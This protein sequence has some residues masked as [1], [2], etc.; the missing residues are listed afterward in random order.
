MTRKHPQV[1]LSSRTA[2]CVCERKARL[3]VKLILR[4]R[5]EKKAKQERVDIYKYIY[6]RKKKQLLTMADQERRCLPPCQRQL[7]DEDLHASALSVWGK[8]TRF[9]GSRAS[10]STAISSRSR[11]F[12]HG[13]PSLK[14]RGDRMSI[15][16]RH[17]RR[18]HPFS[19]ALAGS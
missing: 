17:V 13:S 8:S 10:A 19:R 7:S 1:F 6:K 3:K 5:K 15:W 2:L 12:A 11:C 14:A 18:I 4:K 9:A 16:P